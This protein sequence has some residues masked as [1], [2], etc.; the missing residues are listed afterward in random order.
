[1]A[2]AAENGGCGVAWLM[3][4]VVGLGNPGRKYEGTRHNVGFVVATEVVR[5]F[6]VDRG[7]SRFQAETFEAAVDGQKLLVLMPQTFMN[8]SGQ[9]VRAAFDFFKLEYQDLLVVCDDLALPVGKMRFRAKGSSGGQKGLA[10][11]IRHLGTEEFSRLRLGIGPLPERWD[12]A[13]FVLGKFAVSEVTEIAITTQ[14][15]ADG[16]AD[17]VRKDTAFC[18]NTYN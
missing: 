9:S 4:L 1:V 3:K 15:A 2:K 17:W 18:M 10:D 11:I 5:R 12:A 14:Q 8:R 16:V 7:R 13:D 6:G